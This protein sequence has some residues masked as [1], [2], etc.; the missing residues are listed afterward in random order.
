MITYQNP[1]YC[2]AH[3]K[4]RWLKRKKT[5]Q[6][7]YL[8]KSTQIGDLE[9][10]VDDLRERILKQKYKI[11]IDDVEC[12]AL[13][14]SQLSKQLVNLKTSF[15]SIKEHHK[16]NSPNNPSR[17]VN[18]ESIKLD[19]IIKRCKRI[20]GILIIMK[21]LAILPRNPFLKK[22]HNPPGLPPLVKQISTSQDNMS[23]V[24][25]NFSDD[26]QMT[27]SDHEPQKL[28]I[29][30]D[31]AFNQLMSEISMI[32]HDINPNK[33]FKNCLTIESYKIEN[34]SLDSDSLMSNHDAK[35]DLEVTMN[36]RSKFRAQK[37]QFKNDRENSA[38]SSSS[39]SSSFGSTPSSPTYFS[40]NS[41]P[42]PLVSSHLNGINIQTMPIPLP[43]P[44]CTQYMQSKS[45]LETVQEE[46]PPAT[47]DAET[48]RSHM[49]MEM[50]NMSEEEMLDSV[51]NQLYEQLSQFKPAKKSFKTSASICLANH[52][53]NEQSENSNVSTS[54]VITPHN[55]LNEGQSDVQCSIGN[56]KNSKLGVRF[57]DPGLM[58]AVKSKI[59]TNGSMQ[60]VSMNKNENNDLDKNNFN[61]VNVCFSENGRKKENQMLNAD[62]ANKTSI[63]ST[64]LVQKRNSE[65][66]KNGI[67]SNVM[68]SSTSS[69]ASCSSTPRRV[70]LSVTDL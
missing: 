53:S 8:V 10:V 15:S 7:G 35:L 52:E 3:V 1:K 43:V 23:H 20:T 50:P 60:R 14:L 56:G 34:D 47:L 26:I 61:S 16:Q 24:S 45:Y 25:K 62:L 27:K 30:V 49:E 48:N 21:K 13:A 17:F 42:L 31:A 19:M 6:N 29:E 63:L 28:A 66:S 11:N 37:N 33:T 2:V 18:V 41:S 55:Q 59:I 57:S 22:A 4:Q 9:T 68:G 67:C 40:N 12:Y 46:E 54:M 44:L 51:E 32:A 5:H 70:S 58:K 38:N 69:I 64:V 65:S 36:K 39:T